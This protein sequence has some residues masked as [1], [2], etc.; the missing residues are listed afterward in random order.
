M[1]RAFGAEGD[2]NSNGNGHAEILRCV[3]N[4]D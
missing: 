3:L 4:D 1:W 2:D